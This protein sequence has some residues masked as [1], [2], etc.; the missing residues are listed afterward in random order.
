L[1]QCI[2]SGVPAFMEQRDSN[3]R[4]AQRQQTS[5]ASAATSAL[6]AAAM[7]N[8]PTEALSAAPAMIGGRGQAFAQLAL[9][10]FIFGTSWP[11]LKQGI[12]AGATPL[13]FAVGRASCGALG[14]FVFAA[15]LRLLRLPRRSDLPIIVSIGVLQLGLFFALSNLGLRFVPAGRSA[16]LAYTTSLW[17][18]PL[19][20]IT[21]GDRLDMRRALGFCT[22][23]A[24][25]AILLNPL[26]I[27]WTKPGVLAGH[28]FLLLAALSWAFAIFHARRHSWQGLS[29]LQ[30]LP[31]QMLV[32]TGLLLLLAV[33]EEP[34]G[35]LP[36]APA[37]IV[38]LIYL[39]LLGGPVAIWAATSV[40][41]TL[42]T[43]VSSIGFLGV[44]VIGI[45]VS[46]L[47]LGEPITFPLFLGAGVV[48]IGLVVVAM[49][50]R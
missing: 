2:V 15:A 21:G 42:P 6:T 11:L 28:G 49:A 35:R 48:L 9:V 38:T 31:W 4:A 27:D 44:P 19:E 45:I 47:W 24:G 36:P 17:L 37:V 16:V 14:A 22:G 39:G 26:A 23:I 5:C 18:V 50:Q 29:P 12:A 32:A 33:L 46:T 41:R 34:H 7:E 10:A 43:L 13:W 3:P 20:A 30:A 25:V 1:L 40:S 8:A